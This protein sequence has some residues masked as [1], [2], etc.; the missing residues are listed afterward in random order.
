MATP[1]TRDLYE[2]LLKQQEKFERDIAQRQQNISELEVSKLKLEGIIANNPTLIQEN[3]AAQE[4]ADRTITELTAAM[5]QAKQNIEV[6]EKAK[7]VLA[8]SL[9]VLR[10]DLKAAQEKGDEA[11]IER[12]TAEIAVKEKEMEDLD[13]VIADNKAV[14]Q[15]ANADYQTQQELLS[16]LKQTAVNLQEDL[17]NAQEGLKDTTAELENEQQLLVKDLDSYKA[18]SAE[19]LPTLRRYEAAQESREKNYVRVPMNAAIN[20]V[21]SPIQDQNRLAES[22]VIEAEIIATQFSG[23]SESENAVKSNGLS[24]G[25]EFE[26]FMTAQQALDL[27]QKYIWSF[28]RLFAKIKEAAEAQKTS[29]MV[30]N[31]ETTEA[32]ALIDA[33]YKLYLQGRT[34]ITTSSIS[35][36]RFATDVTISW[37]YM[38]GPQS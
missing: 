32:L 35:G 30:I 24:S 2:Q 31:L 13:K 1:V 21:T 12:L 19:N 7:E 11:E 29:I 14:G 4:T 3:A 33:G 16:S 23:L 27:T 25:K 28:E 10:D 20:R 37:A 22:N 15:K 17:Q 5:D 9:D 26:G 38:Q 8:E 6:A 18:W 36:G 34:P